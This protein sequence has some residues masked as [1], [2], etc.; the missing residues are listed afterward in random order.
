MID[1]AKNEWIMRVLGVRVGASNGTFDLSSFKSSWTKAAETWQG[2]SDAVDGQIGKLQGALRGNNDPDLKRIADAGLNGI[3]GNHK[4]PVMVAIREVSAAG[5]DSIAQRVASAR[6]AVDAFSKHL[7]TDPRVGAC[8][9]NPFGV[10]V[11]IR[12]TLEPA[13][14]SLASTLD[15]AP[16]H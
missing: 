10:S 3:T 8:D 16:S 12:A 14:R 7:A 11:S 5:A 9:R 15:A 4:V 13:L 1:T 6:K 2:A